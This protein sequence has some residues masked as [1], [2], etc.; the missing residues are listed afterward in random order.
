[1]PTDVAVSAA[2]ATIAG[3]KSSPSARDTQKPNANGSTTPTTATANAAP[4]T[5]SKP[6]Q[7]GLEPDA[8]QQQHDADLGEQMQSGQRRVDET[9]ERRTEQYTSQQLADDSGLSDTLSELA[10]QL[11]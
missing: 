3:S 1:M 2:P 8:E 4:P 10:Q 5:L 9:N 7:I 11:R 6:F